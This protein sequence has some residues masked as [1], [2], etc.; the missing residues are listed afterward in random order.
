MPSM[1]SCCAVRLISSFHG[2]CL[3]YECV[4]CLN[5][6]VSV[7]CSPCLDICITPLLCEPSFCLGE[8]KQKNNQVNWKDLSYTGCRG[9]LISMLFLPSVCFDYGETPVMAPLSFPLALQL[10][11]IARRGLVWRCWLGIA[12]RI[13]YKFM[14]FWIWPASGS[15]THQL[16]QARIHKTST[17][18]QTNHAFEINSFMLKAYLFEN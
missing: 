8:K 2:S 1:L 16:L 18:T 4:V 9:P 3:H 5:E 10:A 15:V 7:C 13:V 14:A 17:S 12:E 11:L 6:W